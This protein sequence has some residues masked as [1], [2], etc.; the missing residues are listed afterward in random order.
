MGG[1]LLAVDRRDAVRAAEGDE[2]R[3]GDLRRIGSSREH[4]FA[5]EHPAERDAIEAAGELAVDPRLEAVRATFLVPG[6]V[7]LDHL[8]NDPGARLAFARRRG[9]GGD[10]GAK[11]AVDAQL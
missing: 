6:A 3:Q 5:E 1:A 4:R 10:D 7:G 9:A 11:V 8:G 2:A